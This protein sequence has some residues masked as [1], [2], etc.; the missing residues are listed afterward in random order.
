[1]KRRTLVLILIGM[2]ALIATFVWLTANRAAPHYRALGANWTPPPYKSL[3]YNF[4]AERPFAGDKVWLTTLAS[5][6]VS[7]T[8]LFDL[9]RREV[10]GE[11]TNADPVVLDSSGSKL[12]CLQRWQHQ[13]NDFGFRI[14]R[15]LA[16]ISRRTN[17]FDASDDVPETISMIA[18]RGSTTAAMGE[19]W[20]QSGAG[21]GFQFSPDSRFGAN[22]GSA[23]F[24]RS[25][26]YV[27]DLK[28][29]SAFNLKQDGWPNG[30][31]DDSNLIIKTTASDFIKFD[32]V[33]GKTNLLLS[34]KQVASFL[35]NYGFTNS[36]RADLKSFWTGKQFDFY[37]IGGFEEWSANASYLIKVTRPNADLELIDKKFK[38]EWS[39]RFDPTQHWYVYTGRDAGKGSDAVYLR[40]LK[41]NTERVLVPSL[42]SP[43]F[44][45]PNFW[46]TNV[47]FVRSNR[48]W[49]VS[50]DGG[51]PEQLFPPPKH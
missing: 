31:W 25:E 7:H 19:I 51:N 2:L 12:L 18:F 44:S 28:N 8:Y 10:L 24:G 48:L 16:K 4:L 9:V 17:P 35:A 27:C 15:W 5:N 50:I 43:S 30:W 39:G 40:D 47:V 29:E 33:T 21:T 26:I 45:L 37:L 14:H 36:P 32:V 42:G 3:S 46:G 11:L 38:F 22:K 13:T 6:R 23:Y 1:M 41:S 34:A 49:Q 20:Q